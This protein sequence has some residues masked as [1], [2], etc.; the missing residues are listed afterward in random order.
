MFAAKERCDWRDTLFTSIFFPDLEQMNEDLR[1][2]SLGVWRFSL[3]YLNGA[4]ALD[5]ADPNPWVACNLTHQCFCQSIELGFKSYLL[6]KGWPAEKIQ[7]LGH[8]LQDAMEAAVQEGFPALS[9]SLGMVITLHRYQ[10]NEHRFIVAATHEGLT[11]GALSRIC[12]EVLN[13]AAPHVATAMGDASRAE[14]MRSELW[15]NLRHTRNN[16]VA[17]RK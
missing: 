3:A 2:T 15:S 6:A 5:D 1:L 12:E 7:A 16:S 8:S 11:T 14:I 17:N 9:D 10:P 4:I 13:H